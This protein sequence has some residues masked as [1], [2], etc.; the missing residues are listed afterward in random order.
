MEKTTRRKREMS[1][2][3]LVLA[4]VLQHLRGNR[5]DAGC[6]APFGTW[7]RK[8]GGLIANRA[9]QKSRPR[10]GFFA[11]KFD[12]TKVVFICDTM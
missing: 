2:T 11:E 8:S 12:M 9:D 4:G 5:P 1:L 7:Q 10:V 6:R 3:P